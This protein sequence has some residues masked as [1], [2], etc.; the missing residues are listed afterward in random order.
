MWLFDFFK[1]KIQA[2]KGPTLQELRMPPPTRPAP[3][4]P[5]VQPSRRERV[6]VTTMHDRKSVYVYGA[7]TQRPPTRE[8]EIVD[9]DPSISWIPVV[10]TEGER[11]EGV[12]V[13]AEMTGGGGTF[14]GGGASGDWTDSSSSTSSDSSYSDS[15][16][17]CDS[18][19][20]SF[21]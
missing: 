20:S 13:P 14:D 3:P 16:S 10:I 9:D 7:A 18:S 4:M 15:S 1:K 12:I 5:R 19:S 21:D 11:R 17:S 6:D 2:R 8:Y